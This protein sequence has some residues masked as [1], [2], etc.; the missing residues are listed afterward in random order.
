MQINVA[1]AGINGRIGRE[2]VAAAET[3]PDVVIAAGLTRRDRV[4]DLP[5]IDV[6]LDFTCADSTIELA[7]HCASAGVPFVSGVTGLSPNQNDEISKIGK[8]IPVFCASN[9]SV[10]VC[11]LMH[12]LPSLARA[13]HGYDIEIVETHHRNKTDAPSGTAIDLAAAVLGERDHAFVHGRAGVS[14]R[15]TTD[16]GIH[17][18]R[19]G[20]NTGEHTVLF[21]D[22]GEEIRISHR[23]L[24]RRTFAL[25]ALRA[26]KFVVGRPP[27]LYGMAELLS[28]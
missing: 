16:I 25:G 8:S 21:M 7:H 9:F 24:S 10:G 13:L 4:K 2:I 18:V 14:P 1:I 20:G 28:M 23:A 15:Q 22:D 19:G 3:D 26:S 17:S 11:A 27:G 12:L 5:P 6:L